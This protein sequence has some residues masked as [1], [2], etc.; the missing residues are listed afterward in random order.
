MMRMQNEPLSFSIDHAL[1]RSRGGTHHLD[2]L[3]GAC[4]RCNGDKGSLTREEYAAVLAVRRAASVDTLPKGQDG[5]TRLGAE[6][7]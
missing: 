5:E 7:G 6:Q 4:R 2:N 1:P 3:V